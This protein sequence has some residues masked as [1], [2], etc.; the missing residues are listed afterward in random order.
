MKKILLVDVEERYSVSLYQIF[1]KLDCR[2][3]QVDSLAK[4][5]RFVASTYCDLIVIGA[6]SNNLRFDDFICYIKQSSCNKNVSIIKLYK[7]YSALEESSLFSLGVSDYV[8][9]DAMLSSLEHKF[10]RVLSYDSYVR[11]NAELEN[12]YKRRLESIQRHIVEAFSTIIE[13]RDLST[14]KHIKTTASL[15][16]LIIKGLMKRGVYAE[17]L[18]SEEFRNAIVSAAPLHDLGKINISDNIL[19]KPGRLTT[20]EFEIMKTHAFVGSELIKNSLESIAFENSL[21]FNTAVEMALYHHEKWNGKGY[22]FGK[23]HDDIPIAAR[24]MAV[25]DV[26]DALISKRCYKEQFSLDEAFSIIEK[27]KGSHF[28]PYIAEVFLEMRDEI[29]IYAQSWALDDDELQLA[30]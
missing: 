16:R 9:Q 22:P 6:C 10:S 19:C 29:T 25:A 5:M 23:K 21:V 27:E 2:I 24:I 28:D 11:D 8:Y 18:R 1:S 4:C 12:D 3:H 26:F 30:S 13:G 7:N 20:E 14:G 15:V 17:E